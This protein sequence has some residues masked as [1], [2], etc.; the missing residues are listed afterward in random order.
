MDGAAP[1]TLSSQHR[2]WFRGFKR[3]NKYSKLVG[4]G[5]LTLYLLGYQPTLAIPPIKKVSVQAQGLTQTQVI[6]AD[7]LAHPFNTPFK[8]YLTTRF[9]SWHPGIDIATG[10][11]MPI[12]P[13]TDGTVTSVEYGF[14]GLGHEVTVDHGHGY[15]STYGHMG[16]VFVKVGDQITSTSIIGEVGL[17][18]HTSGPHTHLEITKNSR[19]IDP[20][21]ILPSIS[22]IPEPEFFTAVAPTKP[23]GGNE[24][25]Q[26]LKLNL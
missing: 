22:T 9:S 7:K 26:N 10:L 5:I 4:L 6:E 20:E 18:G 13:I 1:K 24:L 19:Y 11:G 16:R 2:S 3:S 17:T 14:W 23:T 25:K 12:R 21:T 15:R 8:G